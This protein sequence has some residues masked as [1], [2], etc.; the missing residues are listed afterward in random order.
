MDPRHRQSE[1]NNFRHCST[2][3]MSSSPLHVISRSLSPFHRP[4]S[5]DLKYSHSLRAP[6]CNRY[7]FVIRS[8]FKFQS[9]D[10]EP[11]PFCV[12]FPISSFPPDRCRDTANESELDS[13]HEPLHRAMS[14]SAAESRWSL[15][16]GIGSHSLYSLSSSDLDFSA[17][18]A[19]RDGLR[20]AVD[21]EFLQWTM[22][23]ISD[24]DPVCNR[25]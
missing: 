15:R 10:P 18:T 3:K 19:T 6:R 21:P 14:L 2:A 5:C 11:F 24:P 12:R 7:R 9:A 20:G 22:R 23:M 17:S 16:R 4:L 13:L 8:L 1:Y 25:Y